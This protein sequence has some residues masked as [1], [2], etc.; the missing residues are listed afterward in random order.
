MRVLQ[1]YKDYYPVLGGIENHV[2]LLSEGLVQAGH[3]VTALVSN[4]V[5]KTEIYTQNGVRI[6]KAAQ[7]L[8]AASTPISPAMV[9]FG[10]GRYDVIHLH[11]PY[12]PGDLV[13]WMRPWRPPLVITYHSDIVRQRGL[14]QIYRPLLL[15]TLA[16][17]SRIITTSPNYIS[18]SPFLR[19]H[20]GKCR[21]VPLGAPVERFLSADQLAVAALRARYGSP[22]VLFTGKLRY[23]KGLHFLIR[24]MVDVPGAR[25]V[26]VG[27]G[28]ERQRLEALAGELGLADRVFFAGEVADALL[29]AYYHAADV[30]VLP[31]H[32]RSEAYGL[33]QVEAM[34][35]GLP[36][37]STEIGTGTSY[38]NEH[39]CTGFVVPPEAPL[40]LAQAINV[41]L[42][43]PELRAAFGG[44]GRR[45]AG[46]RFSLEVMLRGVLEVYHEL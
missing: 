45:R 6:I 12:P 41:L 26:L 3:E 44:E 40:A 8:R 38:V 31:A 42:A 13:Y 14:L 18:S 2:R 21:V 39:G 23:Y 1:V 7:W 25:L 20:A 4:I 36:L 34:A 17:A 24:A 27:E 5:P 16:A 33:V 29:P 32:L 37:V 43:N 10:Q 35:A 15:R 46:E 9:L 30:F 28:P 22:L 19:V 11:F